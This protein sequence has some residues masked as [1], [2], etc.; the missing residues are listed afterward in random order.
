M[1][2]GSSLC[3]KLCDRIVSQLKDNAS[4]R[5]IGEGPKDSE[6]VFSSQTSPHFSLF[7][8]KSAKTSHCDGME[9]HQCPRHGWYVYMWRYHW[10]CLQNNDF[11]QELHVYFN[12]TMPGLILHELQKCGYVGIECVRLTGLPAVQISLLLKIYDASCRG[13]PDNGDHGT[14][15]SSSLVYTKN[16]QKFHLQQLIFSVPK[17]L[18]SAIKRK[19]NVTQW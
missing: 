10:C 17:W 12:R 6:N 11:T 15:S 7:L 14:L 18:Q 8:G 2:R 3:A 9:V 4:Q 1:G 16:G 19:G 13:E 5:K